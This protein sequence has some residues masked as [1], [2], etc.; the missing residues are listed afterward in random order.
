LN[1]QGRP[2]SALRRKTGGFLLALL[3]RS[4]RP[5]V[6]GIQSLV[7][8]NVHARRA[9]RSISGPMRTGQ[10]T[11]SRGPAKGLVMDV[12]GSRPSY[13]LG[14]A[15]PEVVE[16]FE[17][18]VRP[19][20]V[21]LDLGAN[22]GFF[23]LVSA[24]L[25]GREGKVVAFEPLPQNAEALRRNVAINDLDQVAVVEAAVSDAEGHAD[26]TIG[27]SD[28]QASLTVQRSSEH[29]RVPTVTIDDEMR[30][31]DLVP[32]FV[33][34]DVEGAEDASLIGA[35]HTLRHCRPVVLCEVHTDRPS[36]EHPVPRLLAGLGYRVSWLE[37][38][39]TAGE[40][41]WAPHLLAVPDRL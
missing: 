11:I 1:D 13:L 14:T 37:D 35:A 19:G 3:A 20:G 15:E 21:A 28:Q 22:V 36:L 9:L 18:Y 38:E 7:A 39:A 5:L 31:R 16:I 41:F 30:R 23:T 25:V 6:Q 4:P 24:A 2:S 34:I 29:I 40:T 17:R 32:T 33:K 10:H 12:S 27:P 8:R 26:L